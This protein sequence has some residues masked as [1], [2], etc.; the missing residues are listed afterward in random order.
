MAAQ[1]AFEMHQAYPQ[2]RT[3]DDNNVVLVGLLIMA[4]VAVAAGFERMDAPQQLLSLFVLAPGIIAAAGVPIVRFFK[5][6]RLAGEQ[7]KRKEPSIHGLAFPQT[8]SRSV[9]S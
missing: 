9:P 6:F 4:A 3:G 2:E 5:P 8:N 7:G 1:D